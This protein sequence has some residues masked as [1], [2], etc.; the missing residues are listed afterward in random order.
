MP[1]KLYI[2]MLIQAVLNLFGSFMGLAAVELVRRRILMGTMLLLGAVI[3]GIIGAWTNNIYLV[4]TAGFF[5]CMYIDC[6]TL[7]L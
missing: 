2:N 1:G 7:L 3:A 6:F 5:V 4:V